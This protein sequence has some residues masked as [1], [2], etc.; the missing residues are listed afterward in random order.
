M[1]D[2]D[3]EIAVITRGEDF[4][5]G[6]MDG[7]PALVSQMAQELRVKLWMEHFGFSEEEAL[8]PISEETSELI[9]QRAAKNT[10]LYR[11]IFGCYPDDEMA[12]RK[13]IESKRKESDI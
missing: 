11:R 4:V 1:G 5:E 10:R 7:E 12:T 2:R 3:S 13:D 9:V 6:K 8:D